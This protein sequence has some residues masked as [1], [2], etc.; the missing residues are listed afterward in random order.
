MFVNS[1]GHVSQT[2]CTFLANIFCDINN[3]SVIDLIVEYI[4]T[5]SWYYIWAKALRQ[6][7]GLEPIYSSIQSII[8]NY[9][10]LSYHLFNVHLPLYHLVF[11]IYHN[12]PDCEVSL[13]LVFYTSTLCIIHNNH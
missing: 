13:L 8:G 1:G 11:F 10:L 6:Y 5:Q 12:K 3:T 9:Y 2:P 7:Q 4:G